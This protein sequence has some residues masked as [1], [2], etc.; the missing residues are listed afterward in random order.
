MALSKEG[1]PHGPL[2]RGVWDCCY[3]LYEKLGRAPS[4]REFYEEI[5]KREPDRIGIS[6][7]SRQWG[8]W[9]RHHDFS[10]LEDDTPG[11]IPEEMQSPQYLRVWYAVT[12]LNSASAVDIVR[13]ILNSNPL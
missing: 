8:E 5:A 6:T 11:V 4:R 13:W 2:L 12:K 7:H 3:D 10:A 9:M 1:Y